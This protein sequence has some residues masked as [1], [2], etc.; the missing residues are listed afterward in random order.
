V[1][2][3]SGKKLGSDIADIVFLESQI[4]HSQLLEL[5]DAAEVYFRKSCIYSSNVESDADVSEV[6]VQLLD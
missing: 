5:A 2:K 1:L 4:Q 3:I 6:E